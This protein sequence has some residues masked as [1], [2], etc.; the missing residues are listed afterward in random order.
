MPFPGISLES[1]P[2]YLLTLLNKQIQ[3]PPFGTQRRVPALP[4]LNFSIVPAHSEVSTEANKCF[5]GA[6][7]SLIDQWLESGRLGGVE[8][9]RKRNLGF[10]TPSREG[11]LF[12]VNS[13]IVQDRFS[14][15]IDEIRPN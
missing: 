13:W 10:G 12:V 1:G 8:S 9:P 3:A 14:L 11:L 15:S 5:V 7:Q 6:L 2:E 4:P